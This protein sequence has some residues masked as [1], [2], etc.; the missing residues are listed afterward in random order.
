MLDSYDQEVRRTAVEGLS[1]RDDLLLGAIGLCG[2][3]GEVAETVKKHV[4]HGTP[5]NR[6]ELLE[7]L[8]D[9]L[10]YLTH[11]TRVLGSS[12]DDIAAINVAKL[13]HR[14]PNGFPTEPITPP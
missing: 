3:S 7:E 6:E 12:L 5:L 14:Y 2:E 1:T 13:R 9:V 4:F 10:W 11:L 8:G